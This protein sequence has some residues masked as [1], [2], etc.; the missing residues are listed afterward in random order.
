VRNNPAY[1]LGMLAGGLV[2]GLLCG[3]L[4]LLLGRSRGREGLA[5]GGFATCAAGG[6]VGGLIL[7]VP[8]AI[9]FTV[10]ICCLPSLTQGRR[11]HPEFDDEDDRYPRRRSRYADDY[12][13]PARRDDDDYDRPVRRHEE[14]RAP[15]RARDDW[16]RPKQDGW[17]Q[18]KQGPPKEE[19][20]QSPPSRGFGYREIE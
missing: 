19:P 11:W 4:P 16:P 3:L 13:R 14:D 9:V 1:L 5:W 15:S 7:A 20:K 8:A 18:P 6:F 2:A 17:S 10:I 12:D